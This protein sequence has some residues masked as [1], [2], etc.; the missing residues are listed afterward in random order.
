MRRSRSAGTIVP[1]DEL[2][3][4]R[5][6][7]VGTID[8]LGDVRLPELGLLGT[9]HEQDTQSLQNSSI[10]QNMRSVI[11]PRRPDRKS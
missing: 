11:L 10:H 6:I 8:N 2:G 3:G 7:H 9:L 5:G 1:V 4:L